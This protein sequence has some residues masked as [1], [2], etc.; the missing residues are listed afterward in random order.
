MSVGFDASSRIYTPLAPHALIISVLAVP[1]APP[2]HFCFSTALLVSGD[3]EFDAGSLVRLRALQQK[4]VNKGW[5]AF[6]TL[7]PIHVFYESGRSPIC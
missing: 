1:P 2:A 7:I 6:H 3:T 5:D 4:D